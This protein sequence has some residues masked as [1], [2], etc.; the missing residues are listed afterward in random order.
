MSENLSI[1]HIIW[2]L[3]FNSGNYKIK[4]EPSTI[5]NVIEIK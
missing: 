3:N 4:Y 5:T 1:G 2:C